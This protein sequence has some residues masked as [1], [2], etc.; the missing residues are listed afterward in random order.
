MY[1]YNDDC[2]LVCVNLQAGD[3]EKKWDDDFAGV[4][5]EGRIK[6][7]DFASGIIFDHYYGQTLD[8]NWKDIIQN[9]ND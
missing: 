6:D 2:E 3:T 7:S 5:D 9:F 1:V 8:S 4:F